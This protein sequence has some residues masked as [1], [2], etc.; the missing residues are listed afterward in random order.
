M[1]KGVFVTETFNGVHEFLNII[2]KREVNKVFE[3]YSLSSE[4]CN[5]AFTMTNDYAESEELMSKGYKDGLN[6]LKKCKG[7]KVNHTGIASKNIPQTGIVGY[8][9]HV[10][11]AIAGVPQSM[12][13]SQKIEHRAKIM[14]I[15]YDRSAS[16]NVKAEEF[17]K[18]GRNILDLVMML[19]L[20]GYRV[21]VDIQFAHCTYQERAI[22]R[23]TV[24]NL[25]QPINPLKTSYLLLHPSFSRRQGFRWLETVPE[26]SNTKFTSGYGRPLYYF[27]DDDGASTD[28]I[29]QYL[30]KHDLLEDGTFFTNFYEAVDHTAEEL[31]QLMGIGNKI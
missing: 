1:K 11:N 7:M 19:E 5:Y 30:R 14:T 2:G 16:A 22:C 13:C 31:V 18:A 28:K 12:I 17:V 24:K 15:V 25:R 27:L 3:G 10:P 20:Q 6:D 26:L 8:A 21:R 29:R 9:P 23:I 4:E